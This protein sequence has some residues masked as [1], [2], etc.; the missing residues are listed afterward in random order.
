M[1]TGES[2]Y[3]WQERDQETFKREKLR[4]F[5][6]LLNMNGALKP[7]VLWCILAASPTKAKMW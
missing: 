1:G 5:L 6:D 3:R 7:P 2:I 4:K